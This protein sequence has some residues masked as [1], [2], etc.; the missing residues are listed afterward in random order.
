MTVA[1]FFLFLNCQL[2]ACI[3]AKSDSIRHSIVLEVIL[4]CL[5]SNYTVFDVYVPDSLFFL[6]VF[7]SIYFIQLYCILPLMVNMKLAV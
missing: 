4:K 7:C 6:S 1:L 5:R 2:N 3:I